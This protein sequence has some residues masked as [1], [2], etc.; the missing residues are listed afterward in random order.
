M[1][2][3]ITGATGYLG[4]ALVPQL[5]NCGHSLRILVRE[6]SDQSFFS[7]FKNIEIFKGDITNEK[8][9]EGIDKEIEAVYHLA[10][11][12]HLQKVSCEKFYNDVN[13]QGSINLLKQFRNSQTL[14][15]FLFTTTSAAL[16]AIPHKIVT[17]EDF[18]SPVTPYGRSKYE[19]ELALK[20]YASVHAIPYVMVRLT[21]IYGPG[22]Q[23]DLFRI[24]KMIKKGIFPQIGLTPNLYP[25]VF[26]DDAVQ[27]VMKAMEKGRITETYI[28]T[29]KKS[30]DTREIRHY[31][32]EYLGIKHPFYPFFPKY[33]SLGIFSIFD[34][35]SN[36][37]G[38]KFPIAKKN[39][40]FMTAGRSFSIDKARKELDYEPQVSLKEG[41]QK[42]IAYYLKEN[43][44]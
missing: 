42:T 43:L 4:K 36:K 21:H 18:S 44:L 7:R 39:I 8:S 30:H 33:L 9:L 27:G 40:H 6:T 20:E 41:L 13:N 28:L 26:I 19:A 32:K 5:Y 31:V 3:L 35:I 37:T 15:K 29:D 12:G 17:E 14:K 34:F 1:K 38:I 22:E 10:V 11:L 25:A 2:I 16:G 23:R 24:I